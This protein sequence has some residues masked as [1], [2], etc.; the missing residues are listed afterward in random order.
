MLILGELAHTVFNAPVDTNEESNIY[1][2]RRTHRYNY[3][4]IDII[5]SKYVGES[6]YDT[7]N[8][9]FDNARKEYCLDITNRGGMKYAP[10]N[11]HETGLMARIAYM[12]MNRQAKR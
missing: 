8:V 2:E 3:A 5:A 11:V 9:S 6:D 7:G 1:G 10:Q 4:P 12:I